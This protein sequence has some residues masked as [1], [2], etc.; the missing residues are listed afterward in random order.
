MNEVDPTAPC[1]CPNGHG[2]MT[3]VYGPLAPQGPIDWSWVCLICRIE[4]MAPDE[5]EPPA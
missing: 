3:P 5:P 4:R 1:R 2:Q